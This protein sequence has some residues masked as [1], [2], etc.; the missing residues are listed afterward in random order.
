MIERSPTHY[1]EFKLLEEVHRQLQFINRQ[2]SQ[3]Q[4]KPPA[5]Q[6][7][8]NFNPS[9]GPNLAHRK[10]RS[11]YWNCPLY[12]QGSLHRQVCW[13]QEVLFGECLWF[14]QRIFTIKSEEIWGLASANSFE[15]NEWW[16]QRNRGVHRQDSG[17]GGVEEVLTGYWMWRDDW[18]WLIIFHQSILK[19]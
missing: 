3:H 19:C 17:S 7:Q 13:G 8:E 18:M 4:Y 9:H 16:E 2:G 15:R 10:R 5:L 1:S 11:P 14:A 6:S 12:L